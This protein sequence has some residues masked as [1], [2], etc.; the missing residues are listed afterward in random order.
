MHPLLLLTSPFTSLMLSTDRRVLDE[1]GMWEILETC[2][3]V[4]SLSGKQG[5]FFVVCDALQKGGLLGKE[6]RGGGL[7][8]DMKGD[9]RLSCVNSFLLAMLWLRWWHGEDRGRWV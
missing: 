9:C 8:A 4:L 6:I 5:F 2:T 1:E 7:G 3:V